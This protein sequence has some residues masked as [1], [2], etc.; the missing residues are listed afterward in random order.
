MEYN[1]AA[2]VDYIPENRRLNVLDATQF[3]E[4]LALN[5]VPPSV[6]H[7]SDTDWF[8]L[9]TQTGYTQT[10]HYLSVVVHGNLSYRAALTAILQEGVVINSN[11]KRYIGSLQATQRGLDD[12]LT[13]TFNLNSSVNNTTGSPE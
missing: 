12:K 13:L 9:L 10:I 2:S 3:S 6:N 8:N 4:Q 7:G 5:G 1:V 11:N